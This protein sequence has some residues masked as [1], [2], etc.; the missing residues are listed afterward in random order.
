MKNATIAVLTSAMALAVA[1]TARA[2]STT[3]APEFYLGVDIGAQPN[4]RSI[5]T[6]EQFPLYD[7]TATITT[8]QFVHNGPVFGLNGAYRFMPNFGVGVNLTFFNAR[9]AEGTVVA[10][11]PD[12][13]FYDQ[14][15]TVTSTAAGLKHRET[16]VHIQAMYFR[17]I[18]D[19]IEIA[20]S[21]GPSIFMVKQDLPDVTVAS[22]TQNVNLAVKSENKN[23]FGFNVGFQGM[24]ALNPTYAAALFA[25]YVSGSVDLDVLEGM[26]VGGFQIGLGLRARF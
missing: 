3:I 22:G 20:L 21:A 9:A 26:K 19:K 11:I 15:R 23:G 7:E 25:Q 24:Y 1:G 17:P 10:D 12:L 2:Q 14:H 5:S 18:N 8:N 6:Q 16:G 4:Q 13:L